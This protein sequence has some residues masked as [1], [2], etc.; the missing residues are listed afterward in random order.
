M[1]SALRKSFRN[2]F[3]FGS[4]SRKILT[5]EMVVNHLDRIP[6]MMP[7]ADCPFPQ[8]ERHGAS[9]SYRIRDR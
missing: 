9:D 6:V 4:F 3:R 8:A 1:P 7:R 2:F 5:D